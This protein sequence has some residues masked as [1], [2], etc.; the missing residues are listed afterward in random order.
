M[1]LL[2]LKN[3]EVVAINTLK[4]RELVFEVLVRLLNCL[5]EQSFLERER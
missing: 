5:L 3:Y 1:F 4:G 2:L